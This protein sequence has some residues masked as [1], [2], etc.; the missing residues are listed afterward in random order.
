VPRREAADL[1]YHLFVALRSRGVSL[2][3]V[4]KTL[5]ARQGKS[6]RCGKGFA[7]RLRGFHR[8]RSSE[9]ADQ[10][11]SDLRDSTGI[12]ANRCSWFP[13]P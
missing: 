3:E 2:D 7:R 4:A 5:Q 6:G 1:I 13:M 10:A 11:R 9:S 12:P 8:G